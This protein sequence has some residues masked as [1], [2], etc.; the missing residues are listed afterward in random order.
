MA[1]TS[2]PVPRPVQFPFD[3]PQSL[4]QTRRPL[5]VPVRWAG[6]P[7]LNVAATPDGIWHQ[8]H[9]A[10]PEAHYRQA[11]R[12]TDPEGLRWT[13][14]GDRAYGQDWQWTLT[15]PDEAAY[16][17][18]AAPSASHALVYAEQVRAAL[19]QPTPLPA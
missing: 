17:L 7:R 18:P 11:L 15:G 13:L 14:I 9:V 6:Y 1:Q 19:A 16:T 3:V 2:P 5:G 8:E 10:W 4:A 12:H